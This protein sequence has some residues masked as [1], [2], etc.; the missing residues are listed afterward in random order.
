[1]AQDVSVVSQEVSVSNPEG[2]YA[3]H[4]GSDDERVSVVKHEKDWRPLMTDFDRRL[5]VLE[6]K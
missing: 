6:L 4:L 1:M 5:G 3:E 2:R